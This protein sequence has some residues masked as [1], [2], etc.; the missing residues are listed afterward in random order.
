MD[1]FRELLKEI[2]RFHPGRHCVCNQIHFQSILQGAAI[3]TV[4]PEFQLP[5]ILAQL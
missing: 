5:T 3:V 1:E 2:V 4:P